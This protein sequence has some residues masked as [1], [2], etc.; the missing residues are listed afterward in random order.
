MSIGDAMNLAALSAPDQQPSYRTVCD[1]CTR[2]KVRCLG[3]LP[4]VRCTNLDFLC[5]YSIRKTSR[6]ARRTRRG[7]LH[8]PPMEGNHQNEVLDG[9]MELHGDLAFD[10]D[11]VYCL[12][13]YGDNN[14]N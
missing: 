7:F 8:Q 14:S 2:S 12:I 9:S 3:G 5:K 1:E 4:C 6:G 13:C 11:Q 10:F